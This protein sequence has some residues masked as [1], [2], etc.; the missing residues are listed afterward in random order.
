MCVLE[1]VDIPLIGIAKKFEEIWMPNRGSPI[2]INK[3]SEALKLLQRVRDE[4][5]RFANNYNKI[6]RSK[7]LR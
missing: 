7:R 6:L 1:N 4:A 5:H 3:K 2:I